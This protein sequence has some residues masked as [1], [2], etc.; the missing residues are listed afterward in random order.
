M[1]DYLQLLAKSMELGPIPV[2]VTDQQGIIVFANARMSQLTGYS[3]G[4]LV[5]KKPSMLSAKETK[6]ETYDDLWR[7]I[8]SG[9][10]WHGNLM[11]RRKNGDI[12][13]ESIF[14]API[15]NPE[16]Q[17]IYFVGFWHDETERQKAEEALNDQL[18][19][20]ENRSRT[21][22]LTG[23]YNRRHI[24]VELE[25]ELE[26][27]VRYKRHLAGMMIDLD[28]FKQ[29]NDK[30]GHLVGDRLIKAFAA[31][32]QHSIRKIDI[33]G[34]YGG[35][36]FIVILPEAEIDIAKKVALRLQKNLL[37]YQ[38]NV[39]GDI[40]RFT[41]SIGLFS[42]DAV[43]EINQVSFIEKIDTALLA[44]KRA[45]KNKIVIG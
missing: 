19:E 32:V 2:L 20:F 3:I 1:G 18:H 27:A 12:Y 16:D 33:L 35:D 45:G 40:S 41:A 26:R 21:D 28:D 29:V 24:L 8:L 25:K 37:D 9:Q 5:G 30:H 38:I 43:K 39:L 31:V 22:E 13:I 36:E 10:V 44:A 23:Q 14:I 17:K 34:R 42:F 15:K 4:E 11:N 6:R 7:T